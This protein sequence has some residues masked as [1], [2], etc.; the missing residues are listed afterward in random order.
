MRADAEQLRANRH[1]PFIVDGKVDC[2]RV[3]EFLTDYNEFLYHPMKPHRPF[4]EKD[5]KL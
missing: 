2:A 1:N 3:V 4:I 5:M